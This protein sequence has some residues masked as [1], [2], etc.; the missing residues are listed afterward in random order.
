MDKISVR[1]ICNAAHGEIYSGN[2]KRAGEVYVDNVTSNSKEVAKGTLFICVK[3]ERTDGHK[4]I[5]QAVAQG[6]VC[7]LISE[8]MDCQDIPDEFYFIKVS[9]TLK[10]FQAVA[11]WYRKRYEIPVIGVSGSVGKTTTKEMI[12]CAL[13]A[14]KN[15]VKTIGNKNSQLGV[16]LMMFEIDKDTEIAVIEMG[17]SEK[18]E[19][20]RL[21]HIAAPETAVVTNIGVSHIANLGSRDNIRKEKLCITHGFENQG[22]LYLCGNDDMLKNVTVDSPEIS[23]TD[24]IIFYG[25]ADNCNV[26]AYNIQN[27]GEKTSFDVNMEN[28]AS[29]HVNLSVPGINNVQNACAA[30]CIAAYYGVDLNK[31]AQRLS[32]YTPMAMRGQTYDI[33]GAVIIDDTYNSSPDSVKSALNVLWDRKCGGKRIA[34]LADILELGEVSGELHSELGEYISGAY[35]DGKRTDVLI[36]YGEAAK[37][38]ADAAGK[39]DGI[40]VMSFDSREDITEYLKAR[41]NPGDV[42]L[43]KGSRGMKMDEIVN[44]L[45]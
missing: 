8:D 19:M 34:V 40:E 20:D 44:A 24:R 3:G 21:T 45:K 23:G 16:A 17:I 18:G 12:A 28:K 22:I 35:S 33:N 14:G 9:D 39:R 2:E 41:L 32:E 26:C 7:V 15:V 10:A 13:S 5:P 29:V 27:D 31:A 38:I 4:Y 6:A 11:A 43:I 30:L 36:T 25:S 37:H 42:V 1:D